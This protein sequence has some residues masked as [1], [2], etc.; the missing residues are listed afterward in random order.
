[1]PKKPATQ[2]HR[3]I[4]Y[5]E[6]PDLWKAIEASNAHGVTK[7]LILTGMV[8]ALRFGSIQKVRGKHLDLQ[9]GV[10]TIPAASGPDDEYRMKSGQEFVLK[11]PPVLLEKL[12]SFLDDKGREKGPTD[13]LFSSPYRR[14]SPISDTAVRK[15]LKATNHDVAFHGFRNTIKI[16]GK[17][18]GFDRDLMDAYCQHGL[19]GLDRSYRRED[20][21]EARYKVTKR[22]TTFVL[23][24]A[25]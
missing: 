10:W 5:Q 12:R 3:T 24:E 2:H 14:S 8:T 7:A 21:L 13:F 1:M 16:W 25:L 9:T 18:N 6:L 11:L 19:K 20:T 15:C 22:L 23:G 17:N 4:D